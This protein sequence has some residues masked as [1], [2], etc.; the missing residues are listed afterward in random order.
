MKNNSE[1]IADDLKIKSIMKLKKQA[2][3]NSILFLIV[4]I[5]LIVT[6]NACGKD[7]QSKL[8]TFQKGKKEYT[9]RNLEK[10]AEFFRQVVSEDKEFLP[11]Q[12]M[13]GKSLFFL[14]KMEES[15]E[16]FQKGLTRFPGNSTIRFWIARI[17]MLQEGKTNEAKQ[18]LEYILE[19]EETFFD[20]HYY[21]AKIYEKEG[22]LKEA[23]IEYNRAK[24]IK[25]GFDKIHRDLGKLYDVAGLHEKAALEKGLL[26]E[27]AE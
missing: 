9:S 19:T 26:L 1:R 3:Q 21:L 2:Y 14:G 10:A 4:S 23:L 22:M 11:A 7:E 18:E 15:E 20:A 13:L 25:I 6:L 8:E 27:K 16:V 5:S 24:M 12:I 17:H